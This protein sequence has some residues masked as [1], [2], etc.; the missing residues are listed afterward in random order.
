MSR[1]IARL[2]LAACALAACGHSEPFVT[3]DQHIDGPFEASAPLQ[4]TYSPL[5]DRG[6]AP[7]PDGQW[8]GYQ[9]AT[10][11]SD[12]DRCLAVL[13]AG[14]G[15]QRHRLCAWVFDEGTRADGLAH[16]AFGEGG[17]IAFT[18]HSGAI[19]SMTSTRAGLYVGPLDSVAGSREVLRL[20]EQPAGASAT[21]TDIIDPQWTSATELTGLA[22]RRLIVNTNPCGTC[23]PPRDSDRTPYKDTVFL[24]VEIVR[25]DVSSTPAVIR[26]AVPA[27][28]AIDWSRD[29]STGALHYIVQRSD[30]ADIDIRHES[31]ADTLMQVASPN[32]PPTAL[33]GVPVAGSGRM[34]ERLHGVTNGHGRVFISRSWRTPVTAPLP[35]VPYG[36]DPLSEISEVLP[37]GSLRTVASGVSWRWGKLRISPDGRYLYAEALERN[38]ADLYRVAIP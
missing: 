30:P 31:V 36:T 12:G 9:Y 22:A 3:A 17:R 8:L 10:G 1:N 33:Y 13:P 27:F 2:S 37:D 28:E 7:S 4:L 24:G 21:W 25:L 38:G 16:L 14:G 26:G 20:M 18:L 34:L 15:Q 35:T 11:E 32:A 19:G 29:A 6:P 5:Y 23:P